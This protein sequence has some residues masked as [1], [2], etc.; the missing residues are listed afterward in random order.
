MA[1]ATLPKDAK[2]ADE[3]VGNVI[4]MEHVNVQIDEQAKATLLYLVGMGF[5]RDPHMMVGLTNMWVNLGE[6]QFH[7][8]T[9]EAQVLRGHIGVVVPSLNDLEQRFESVKNDL[10]GTKFAWKREDGYVAATCPWGNSFRIYEPSPEFGNVVQGIPYVAFNAPRNTADGI[11]TFYNEIIGAPAHV[12]EKDGNKA[13]IV[14][15]GRYQHLIFRETDDTTPYDGHHIAVYITDFS[16][17]Y[18]K[19]SEL[20]LVTEE[21]ANHQLRFVDIVDPK[22]GRK[23]YQIEHEVRSMRHLLYARPLVNRTVGQFLE[24]TRINGQTVLGRVM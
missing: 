10:A 15:I 8:P 11:A 23:L 4:L 16:S 5:T 21:P 2:F 17:V 1:N 18:A 12:E 19:L 14:D 24:P 3:D 20:G 7:L 9:R 22:D 6:Q 13:A